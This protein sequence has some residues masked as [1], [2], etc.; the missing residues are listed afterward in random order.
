LDAIAIIVADE[1]AGELAWSAVSDAFSE[2]TYEASV[3]FVGDLI[4]CDLESLTEE[5]EAAE[6]I[7][8]GALPEAVHDRSA[9]RPVSDFEYG[10]APSGFRTEAQWSGGTLTPGHTYS[11][12]IIG[13]F[14]LPL[15][16]GTFAA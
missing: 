3:T 1:S 12:S 9:L 5:K 10:V 6:L 4:S 13:Q 15:A 8:A 2:Q 11:V 7:A 16:V 14:A